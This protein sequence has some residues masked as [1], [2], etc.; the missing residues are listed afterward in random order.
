MTAPGAPLRERLAACRNL[1]G[2]ESAAATWLERNLHSLPFES[3]ADIAAGAGVSEMSVSR[4]V[5]RL[6]YQNFRAL[7]A[8]LKGQAAT[9]A[10]P[11]LDDRFHRWIVPPENGGALDEMLWREIEAIID[12]YR[13]AHQPVWRDALEVVAAAERVKVTG[14]QAPK[15][16][17]LDFAS[18]L[19]WVRPGV[20]FVEGISGTWSELFD[21][22]RR[23]SCI[24]LVDTAAYARTSFRIAELCLREA[25]PLVIVTI[26]SATGPASTR[27]TSCR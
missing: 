21:E 17:A 10:G 5:R 13:L 12:V 14:F 4:F 25:L 23:S 16:L 3:A 15:G 1:S 24:V 11:E 20:R 27:R 19:E 22:P 2:A 6:G 7:K 26:A 9:T 18:R 8:S